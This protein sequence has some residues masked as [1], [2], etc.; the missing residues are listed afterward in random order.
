MVRLTI[1][2]IQVGKKEG[3]MEHKVKCPKCGTISEVLK[4]KYG[5][6]SCPK[7][8]SYFPIKWAR[9]F[10]YCNYTIGR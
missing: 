5:R 4:D 9:V 6:V 2:I 8:G 3:I 7:C 10:I 1:F